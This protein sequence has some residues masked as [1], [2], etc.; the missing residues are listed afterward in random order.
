MTWAGRFTMVLT[1]CALL[2]V[3]FVIVG[4]GSKTAEPSVNAP[5]EVSEPVVEA[6]VEKEIPEW[7][8]VTD[9]VTIREVMERVEEYSGFN[10]ELGDIQVIKEKNEV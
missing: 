4:C 8:K 3:S 1:V 7:R 9:D 6:P 5:V 2:L 10:L